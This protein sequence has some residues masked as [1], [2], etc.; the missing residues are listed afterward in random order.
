MVKLSTK[1]LQLAIF[2][3]A[4][5]AVFWPC[6]S[7][8]AQNKAQPREDDYYKITDIP[9]PKGVALEVGGLGWY[10]KAKTR[11]LVCTRRG[12]LWV[13]DNVYAKTPTVAEAQF[14]SKDIERCF[15]ITLCVGKHTKPHMP[16]VA[17]GQECEGPANQPGHT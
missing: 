13:L 1:S 2:T 15:Q 3:L 7:S 6:A 8:W 14:Q 17:Q 5:V 4:I 9:L 11:L 16:G 10:D 12:E